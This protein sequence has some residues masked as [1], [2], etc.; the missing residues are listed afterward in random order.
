M[1]DIQFTVMEETRRKILYQGSGTRDGCIFEVM[2][3]RENLELHNPGLIKV[4]RENKDAAAAGLKYV[5]K[6]CQAKEDRNSDKKKRSLLHHEQLMYPRN[7]KNKLMP[8][9]KKL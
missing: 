2:S 6:T 7:I 4:V 9:M 8:H 5:L 1:R 3:K